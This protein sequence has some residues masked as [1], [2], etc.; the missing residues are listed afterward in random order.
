MAKT[1]K[2][3]LVSSFLP[4]QD[5]L[6]VQAHPLKVVRKVSQS[7][8][9]RGKQQLVSVPKNLSMGREKEV[10]SLIHDCQTLGKEGYS[11]SVMHRPNN[12]EINYVNHKSQPTSTVS[13]LGNSEFKG[14]REKLKTSHIG[15]TNSDVIVSNVTIASPDSDVTIRE[16][17]VNKPIA[18]KRYARK[19]SPVLSKGCF[20]SL[21]RLYNPT[22]VLITF[23]LSMIIS[24]VGGLCNIGLHEHNSTVGNSSE[25]LNCDR[26][27]SVS[28]FFILRE[29]LATLII[30]KGRLCLC[31]SKKVILNNNK[32]WIRYVKILRIT[33]RDEEDFRTLELKRS[34]MLVRPPSTHRSYDYLALSCET[35]ALIVLAGK[36]FSTYIFPEANFGV[37]QMYCFGRYMVNL[38]LKDHFKILFHR[39]YLYIYAFY[40]SWVSCNSATYSGGISDDIYS[41][42]YFVSL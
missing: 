28:N 35:L 32:Q 33:R 12:P 9:S 26:V 5:P 4:Q 24:V 8:Q 17:G 40:G 22:L 21:L 41:L 36:R 30:I 39:V 20:K 29:F 19:R 18:K 31:N 10:T 2:P 14:K 15:S 16:R 3:Y 42:V 25:S 11:Y 34:N 38:E 27:H 37:F 13:T 1:N 23:I 7:E 6:V